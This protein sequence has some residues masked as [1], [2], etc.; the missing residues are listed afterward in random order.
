MSSVFQQALAGQTIT[1]ND[2]QFGGSDAA[3]SSTGVTYSLAGSFI[4]D[5]ARRSVKYTKFVLTVR[6]YFYANN[7]AALGTNLQTV[8][9]KLSQPGR[10]L[11]I[12]GIGLGF[13]Q[14]ANDVIWGVLPIGMPSITCLGPANWEVVFTC[15]FNVSQCY[16]IG[17]NKAWVAFNYKYAWQNDF[18]GQTTMALA[19]HIEIAQVRDQNNPNLVTKVAEEMRSKFTAVT[20]QGYRRLDNTWDENAAKT[21]IDFSIVDQQLPGGPPPPGIISA[22]GS[23]NLTAAG[24]QFHMGHA[25]ASM[26]LRVAPGVDPS[27]AGAIFLNAVIS[28]QQEMIN[29]APGGKGGGVVPVSLSITNGRY[30]DERMTM[31]SCTWEINAPFKDML[32]ALNI[33][34]PFTASDYPAW[35]TS[36][37][38]LWGNRG[39]G[40][41]A[42][43]P[44]DDV[45]I[46]LC[47]ATTSK[48]I[49]APSLEPKSYP[50]H[51]M[52]SFSCPDVP[53][54]GGWIRYEQR[55]EIYRKD[56]SVTHRKAVKYDPGS[57]QPPSASTDSVNVGGASYTQSPP[58]SH[59][60]EYQG[61]PTNRVLLRYSGL[62][63][64]HLPEFPVITSVSGKAVRQISS[65][66]EPVRLAFHLFGG[67]P[68]W[69][70]G[71]WTEYEVLDGPIVT[72]IKTG[73]KDQ[74]Y[75]DVPTQR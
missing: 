59:V 38:H 51:R 52:P 20:P 14:V 37:E 58:E 50:A 44:N 63:L 19:G 46:S 64:K 35:R 34:K 49:G 53:A 73:Q 55:L 23:F 69:Y 1:Y 5:D 72:I 57:I 15:E 6:A 10:K 3:Y 42:E 7:A 62:R 8:F 70:G 48:T 2:V 56:K 24:K 61:Y 32:A 13:N 26:Q 4:Y 25:T 66:I 9:D 43:N 22:S 68:V 54:D 41:L 11:K 30:D 47:N 28:K 17:N 27:L 29:E 33:W 36:I 65:A 18:E 60:I 12:E 45:I 40:N 39:N 71:G 75:S 31:G 67:C 21:R 74:S 16:S